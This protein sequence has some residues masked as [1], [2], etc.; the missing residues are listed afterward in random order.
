MI[1]ASGKTDVPIVTLLR[2]ESMGVGREQFEVVGHTLPASV[3]FDGLLGLNFLR[4]RKL[5]IDF[6][7]GRIRLT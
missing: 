1:T 7:K 2:F 5:S 3:Q 6:V 4:D